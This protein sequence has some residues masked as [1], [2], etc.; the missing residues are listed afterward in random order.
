MPDPARRVIAQPRVEPVDALRQAPVTGLESRH[1]CTRIV[2]TGSGFPGTPC[3]INRLKGQHHCRISVQEIAMPSKST[4]PD[5]RALIA[6]LE[7]YSREHKAIR[8]RGNLRQFLAE[9]LPASPHLLA[10]NSHQYMWDMLRWKHR[11]MTGDQNPDSAP[12][13]LFQQE[14]YGVDTALTRVVD[15]FKAASAGTEVGRRLLLL[16][17]PPS[18]GKSS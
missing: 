13:G 1:R 7:A 11:S 3:Q 2:R 15:Y 14:L 6:S 5:S 12:T 16:L 8:W 9:V 18:G 10:R 4:E 17:G